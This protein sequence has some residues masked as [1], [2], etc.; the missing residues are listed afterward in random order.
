MRISIDKLLI[1]IVVLK[2]IIAKTT[3]LGKLLI[4]FCKKIEHLHTQ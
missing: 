3:F 4:L 2:K 1:D